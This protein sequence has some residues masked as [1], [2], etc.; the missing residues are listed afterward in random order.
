MHDDHRALGGLVED[1]ELE[2]AP[3]CHRYGAPP[4]EEAFLEGVPQRGDHVVVILVRTHA[5]VLGHEQA[6]ERGAD[7]LDERLQH[8]E[9]RWIEPE[10]DRGYTEGVKPTPVELPLEERAV[11]LKGIRG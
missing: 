1:L 6:E 5:R 10:D 8:A 11:Q 4:G 3:A 9:E 7:L 2:P